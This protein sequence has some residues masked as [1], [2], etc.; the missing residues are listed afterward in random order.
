MLWKTLQASRT[1]AFLTISVVGAVIW[2]FGATAKA[3]L[4]LPGQALLTTG[5]TTFGGP[6]TTFGPTGFTAKDADNNVHFTGDLTSTVYSDPTNPFGAGDLD[7]VYQFSSSDESVDSIDIASISSFTGYSTNA[8]YLAASGSGIPQVV[9]RD[10]NAGDTITYTFTTAVAPGQ[11]SVDLV[12]QTNATAYT[13]G[14]FSLQ[15][16]ANVTISAPVPAT[17]PEP[18]TL[19]IAGF[20]IAALGMRR[21]NRAGR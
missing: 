17:V 6:S 2:G 21:R 16:G 3:V 1:K 12:I 14:N 9:S 10:A 7:F 11:T 19:A 4:I 18:A 5:V 13:M 20:G 15:D 8:D